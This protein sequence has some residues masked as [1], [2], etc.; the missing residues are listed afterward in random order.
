MYKFQLGQ[1]V[2]IGKY[3]GEVTALR[4]DAL[5]NSVR[6]KTPYNEDW[7]NEWDVQSPEQT[8]EQAPEEVSEET[9]EEITPEEITPRK[10]RKGGRG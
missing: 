5:G 10:G 8:L 4:T 9:P 7:H 2:K 6:V 3:S 1:K